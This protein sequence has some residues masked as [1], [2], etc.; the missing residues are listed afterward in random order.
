MYKSLGSDVLG[1]PEMKWFESNE[2]SRI[3]VMQLL[4]PSLET[5][6]QSYNQR[7]S[8]ISVLTIADQLVSSL[9]QLFIST[10]HF[11]AQFSFLVWNTY[12]LNTS[13]IGT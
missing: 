8:L 13:F 10:S 6:F 11:I 5:I 7:Y 1:V 2:K 4:G 9:M 3:L 12:T